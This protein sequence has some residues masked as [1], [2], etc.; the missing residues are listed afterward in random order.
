MNRRGIN[1]AWLAAA[2]VLLIGMQFA[3]AAGFYL[4]EV[5]TPGSLGTAGVANPTNTFS[6]DAAWTNPA[7]MTGMTEDSILAG[8][9]VSAPKVEFDPE[10][11]TAGGSDGGNAGEPGVIPSFFYT[12][13]LSERSRFGFSVTAPFGGGLDYGDDFVA[14][15]AVQN[16]SLAGLAFTPAY[17]YKVNDR[18][19]LGVGVSLL[20][21]ALE[22]E[23]AIRRLLPGPDGQ[24]KF[25]ELDDWGYQAILGLTYR[26]S[27]ET[28]IGVVYRSEAAV[29]LEGT[30]KVEGLA[31]A[32]PKQDVRI[33]WDN[34]QWLEV[35]VRHEL[36]DKQTLFFNLGWQ[37]WSAF[38]RNELSVTSAPNPVVDVTDRNWDNT[39]HGGVAY[40]HK[41][42]EGKY[43]SLGL[44]YESSPV[45]DEDRT[46]DFPVDAF[47][48]L[49]GAYTWQGSK[50]LSYAVGA[51]LYI[52]GD[53]A[54]DQTDQG[55]RVSGEFD[56]NLT[57]FVGGTVRYVF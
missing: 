53:A 25:E 44:S 30:L 20:Y 36:N 6:A 47:W 16:V 52:I 27:D 49:A 35:G 8:L 33:Q 3:H 38:S 50:K 28:L 4:S 21:S 57:L 48:K 54:I 37:E 23:I 29:D 46:F 2:A 51:T 5:G 56:K 34:P 31:I 24:A 32:V 19:S 7:G 10:V 14:R 12:K 45:D 17:A 22:Q 39:W 26:V 18:L 13:I 43:Y 15:Y 11:A 55:V 41:L 42:G 1:T 40:A 9:M